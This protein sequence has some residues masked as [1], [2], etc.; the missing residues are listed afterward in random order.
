MESSW[1]INE[2][3]GD[4]KMAGCWEIHRLTGASERHRTMELIL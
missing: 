2:I 3:L 4:T 1:D